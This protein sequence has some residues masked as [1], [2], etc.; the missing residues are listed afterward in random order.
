MQAVDAD[1][2]ADATNAPESF[3]DAYDAL[4]RSGHDAAA[5]VTAQLDL[6]LGW[7]LNH[8]GELFA[9]LRARRPVLVTPGPGPVLVTRYRDVLEVA[10]HDDVFSV[11]PYGQAMQRVNGGPNFI[12][13]MDSSPQF[14]HDLALLKLVVRRSDQDTIRTVVAEAAASLVDAARAQGRLDVTD[15]GRRAPAMLAASY[16]GVPGPTPDTLM[17]WCRDM[18]MEIFV[19]FTEDPEIRKRGLDGGRLFRDYVDGLVQ[20][21]H[22]SDSGPARSCAGCSTCRP[23][24]R[25]PSPTPV[26]GTT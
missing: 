7:L 14:D 5:V 25:W 11:L 8:P 2:R 13:G 26:S 6:L 19:N 21:A 15:Y 4:G 17:S 20:Q 9:E 3:L 1:I 10:G 22:R 24:L 23:C 16:F 12:L 18:F